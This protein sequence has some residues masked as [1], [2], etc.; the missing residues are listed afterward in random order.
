MAITRRTTSFSETGFGKD[1]FPPVFR[2]RGR[3][4]LLTERF[5]LDRTWKLSPRQGGLFADREVV[6]R[7]QAEHFEWKQNPESCGAYVRTETGTLDLPE[8]SS[9]F[10][11]VPQTLLGDEAALRQFLATLSPPISTCDPLPN[12]QRDFTDTEFEF[13]PDHP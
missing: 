8:T 12:A 1:F 11:T 7:M 3:E 2:G 9:E 4:S 5:D 13:I 6:T 10:Y